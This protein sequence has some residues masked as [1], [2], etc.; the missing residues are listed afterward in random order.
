MSHL[1]TLADGSVLDAARWPLPDGMQDGVLNRAQLA[2]AFTV[3][4]N[5][6]TKWMQQGMPVLSAGQNGVAYEFVLSH[7]HAWRMQ[8]EEA[9]RRERARGD[10]LAAQAAL[11]FRNLESDQAE[12]EATLTAKDVSEWAEA[13]Y[14]RNRAAEQRGDLIRVDRVRQAVEEMLT[15][16]RTAV[17]TLP[18]YAEREFGLTPG[19]VAKMQTRCDE[20]LV[21][22]RNGIER[23]VIAAGQGAQLYALDRGEQGQLAL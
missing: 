20:V 15:A 1:I 14:K 4:E 16:V 18:D 22:M 13:E 17:Y 5:T 8:R 9:L 19:Q 11:A 6:I 7:C 23:N 10:Q 3:S 21:E 12:E 2:V